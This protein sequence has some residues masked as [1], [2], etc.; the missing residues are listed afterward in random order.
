MKGIRNKN[1]FTL[2]ELIATI[3]IIAVLSVIAVFTFGKIRENSENKANQVSKEAVMKSAVSYVDEYYNDSK[4]WAIDENNDKETFCVPVLDLVNK[5]FLKQDDIKNVN[6]NYVVLTRGYSNKTI[7][8]EEYDDQGICAGSTDDRSGLTLVKITT[9]SV[10]LKADCYGD[11]L[12]NYTFGLFRDKDGKEELKNYTTKDDTYTFD[13]L[14][15]GE[16][17]YFGIKCNYKNSYSSGYGFYMKEIV[18]FTDLSFNSGDVKNDNGNNRIYKEVGIKFNASNIYMSENAIYYF[19]VTSSDSVSGKTVYSCGNGNIP[20]STCDSNGVTKL[21][22]GYWYK[23][24]NLNFKDV[25]LK[26]YNNSLIYA[27]IWDGEKFSTNKSFQVILPTNPYVNINISHNLFDDYNGQFFGEEDNV[28]NYN[29]DNWMSMP[30]ISWNI[31]GGYETESK[32]YYSNSGNDDDDYTNRRSANIDSK[33]NC[34]KNSCTFDKSKIGNNGGM[35]QIKIVVTNKITRKNTII[36]IN[37]NID[38]KAPIL[39]ISNSSGGKWTNQNIVAKLNYSDTYSGIDKS[40]IQRK[41]NKNNKNWQSLSYNENTGDIWSDEGDRVGYY[42]VCDYAGNCVT[43][44]SNFKIDKTGPTLTITNSSGGNWTNQNIT[45]KL[46]YSDSASGINAS[47]L[48]WKD[49]ASQTT[50]KSLGNTNTSTRSETWSEEG[51]R[52]VTYKICDNAG[53]CTEKSTNIRIDKSAPSTPGIYN[54]TSGNWTNKNFSLTLSSSDSYSGIAYYQYTYNANATTTGSNHNSDWVTYSNSVKTSF[55]TSEFSAERNQLVYVRACDN[56]GN[57]SS[58]NST[59]IRIDKTPPK[60]TLKLLNNITKET[61]QELVKTGGKTTLD[62]KEGDWTYQ[63]P[64]IVVNTSDISSTYFTVNHNASG[65]YVNSESYDV[66]RYV[67][68]TWMAGHEYDAGYIQTRYDGTH[69]DTSADFFISSGGKRQIRVLVRDSAG[70][71]TTFIINANLDYVQPTAPTGY[72]IEDSQVYLGSSSDI[73]SGL[74]NYHYEAYKDGNLVHA[75]QGRQ[76][77]LTNPPN[78]KLMVSLSKFQE[79]GTYNIYGY[80]IDRAGAA[81]EISSRVLYVEKKSTNVTNY[82]SSGYTYSGGACI[83]KVTTTCYKTTEIRSASQWNSGSCWV[84][85]QSGWTASGCMNSGRA[86]Y[87]G[88]GGQC[89]LYYCRSSYSCSKTYYGNVYSS[90]TSTCPS[91]YVENGN[92]CYKLTEG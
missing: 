54:P 24:E 34:A 17:Y 15:S 81:S 44:S 27:K 64:E 1:G 91:G 26:I 72:G 68:R 63:P 28:I 2:I 43:A 10:S 49:N 3:A 78:P 57:C 76:N 61:E 45:V 50:W 60:V 21:T 48:E 11:G 35:Q 5:G 33:Y 9:S 31:Y 59:Y 38:K 23:T 69:Q 74:Y 12:T 82:C 71:E 25:P 40:T 52:V 41:D 87:T 88:N 22:K 58:K 7:I 16:T 13:G 83:K 6:Y 53:N 42:K 36:Y 79:T 75:G 65:K 18:G 14:T 80:A 84:S 67:T 47:S 51:N 46:N 32:V 19:K 30:D 86:W 29:I 8:S 20:S 85:Y 55:V 62:Y 66:D 77:I 37:V 89:I 73:G 90:S 4:Y 56:V 92:L 70:N 39:S